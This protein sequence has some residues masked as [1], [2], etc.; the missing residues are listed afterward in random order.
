MTAFKTRYWKPRMVYV[1]RADKAD[2]RRVV[3]ALSTSERRRGELDDLL[4]PP[5]RKPCGRLEYCRGFGGS[6]F[7]R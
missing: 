1:L 6:M 3:L 2:M 4:G 7:I 5:H